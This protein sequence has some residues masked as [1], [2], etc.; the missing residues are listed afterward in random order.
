MNFGDKPKYVVLFGPPG[1]GKGTQA[2]IISNELGLPSIATGDMLRAHLQNETELGKIAKEYLAKGELVPDDVTIEMVRDALVQPRCTRG[3]ILDGFPRTVE[4]A[5]ALTDMVREFSGWL[6]VIFIKVPEEVLVARITGRVL[7]RKCGKVYHR[8][9]NPPPPPPVLCEKGGECD[10]YT[11]DDD[12]VEIVSNRIR[13]YHAQ[14]MPLVEYFDRHGYLMVVD[15]TRGIEDVTADILQ[16]L[17][18]DTG[19]R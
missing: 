1:A 11:R 19:E 8:I 13:V 2:Q 17:R 10:F 4:Q 15:G 5:E 16:H 14:T 6:Q 3:V 7:C 12:E 9:F 18:E